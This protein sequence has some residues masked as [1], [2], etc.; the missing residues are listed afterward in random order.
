MPHVELDH[1]SE[2]KV[3]ALVHMIEVGE[4]LEEEE[5]PKDNESHTGQEHDYE[6]PVH[7]LV[8]RLFGSR[9]DVEVQVNGDYDGLQTEQYQS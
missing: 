3:Q 8:V 7:L 2:P 6:R 5:V 9:L 4:P 1:L